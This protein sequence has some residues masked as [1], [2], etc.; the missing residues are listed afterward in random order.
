MGA[1]L[2]GAHRSA[3]PIASVENLPGNTDAHFHSEGVPMPF[4]S[5][6]QREGSN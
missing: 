1:R 5:P 4:A 6:A 2:P 3:V